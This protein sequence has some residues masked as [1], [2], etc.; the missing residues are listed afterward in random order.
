MNAYQERQTSGYTWLQPMPMMLHEALDEPTRLVSEPKRRVAMSEGLARQGRLA[1]AGHE[2][3]ITELR[4]HFGF[5]LDSSVLTFLTVHRN[6]PQLL[7]EAAIH[8]NT[9]FGPETVFNLRAPIDDSGVR[10]LYAVAMWPG[11]VRYVRDALARF[12]QAWWLGHSRQAASY[13][14]FTY[15]LV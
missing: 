8:L 12:D 6:L 1:A 5:P 2:A 13:L 14:N 15:E 9:Y 3:T 10:T 11:N 4:R 7:L